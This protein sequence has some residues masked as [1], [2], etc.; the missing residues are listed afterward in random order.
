MELKGK[1]RS[2]VALMLNAADAALMTSFTEGSPQFIKEAMACGAPIVSTPVGDV[3][4]L[5]KGLE[6][7]FVVDYTAEEIKQALRKAIQFREEHTFTKGPEWLRKRN[8]LPVETAKR[9]MD[10]YTEVLRR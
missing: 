5:C 6:G 1:T 2:E 7:H 9:I 10:V 3:P 4:E 8:I